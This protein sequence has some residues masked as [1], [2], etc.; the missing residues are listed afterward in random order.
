MPTL[1]A[2]VDLFLVL[3]P[4]E[5]DVPVAPAVERSLI[6][7]SSKYKI[8]SSTLFETSFCLMVIVNLF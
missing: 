5:E 4:E 1:L 3:T 7:S 8:A 6:A 2:V